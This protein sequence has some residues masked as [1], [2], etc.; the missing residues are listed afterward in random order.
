MKLFFATSYKGGTGRSVAVLNLA[1]HLYRQGHRVV[2]LDLDLFAPSLLN[3]C[4]FVGTS[5]VRLTHD[6]LDKYTSLPT[7]STLSTFLNEGIPDPY[8]IHVEPLTMRGGPLYERKY[9]ANGSI[10]LYPSAYLQD[11]HNIDYGPIPSRLDRFLEA[12]SERQRPDYVIC[13]LSSGVS[14]LT[15]AILSQSDEVL[16]QYDAVWL[17][18]C[19]FTPQQFSGLRQ[20]LRSIAELK[21]ESIGDTP[22]SRR[23]IRVVETAQPTLRQ[24][25]QSEALFSRVSEH[26]EAVKAQLRDGW[27]ITFLPPLS[28]EVSLLLVEGVI[29]AD[30]AYSKDME[31]LT[32]ELQ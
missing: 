15:R 17:V 6:D 29:S 27:H 4:K 8:D 18:F 19:R 26:A 21:E 7:E 12:V 3:I 25:E 11:P 20:L 24:K 2:L 14:P 28:F 30:H 32:R 1:Y 31:Q 22:N 16:T 23:I 5:A 10:W 13:D 9:R